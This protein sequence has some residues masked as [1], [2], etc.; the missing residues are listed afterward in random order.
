M[1][2]DPGN[3]TVLEYK[4]RATPWYELSAASR[5]LPI[6]SKQWGPRQ[7]LG[8]SVFRGQGREELPHRVGPGDGHPTTWWLHTPVAERAGSCG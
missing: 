6:Q 4:G 8:Q 1:R 3:G 2:P 7:P 5:H